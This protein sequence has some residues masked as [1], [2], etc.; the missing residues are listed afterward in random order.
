M[1]VS[2]TRRKN[3]FIFVVIK[4]RTI[5][6][7]LSALGNIYRNSQSCPGINYIL[8]YLQ[9]PLSHF[10]SVSLC[11]FFSLCLSLFLSFFFLPLFL[12]LYLFLTLSVALYVTLSVS[13][14]LCL[15]FSLFFLYLY[16]SFH[17]FS[18]YFQLISFVLYLSTV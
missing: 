16:L 3:W 15:Y 17:I 10:L 5:H 18:C 14:S 13:L 8:S 4:F 9:F 6:S 12:S 2:E 1:V 7:I 11:L